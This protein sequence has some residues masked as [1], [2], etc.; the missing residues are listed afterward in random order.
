MTL[1]MA[2]TFCVMVTDEVQVISAV[3]QA[4]ARGPDGFRWPAPHFTQEL[5]ARAACRLA[6]HGLVS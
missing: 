4:E 3:L 6:G 1:P 5:E 2:R